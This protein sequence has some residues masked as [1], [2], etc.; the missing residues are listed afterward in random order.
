MLRIQQKVLP[1]PLSFG[2]AAEGFGG[3]AHLEH[4]NNVLDIFGNE[5][6]SLTPVTPLTLQQQRTQK[7]CILFQSV[8]DAHVH[9]N[10]C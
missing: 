5:A 6:S 7:S 1:P 2:G 10:M 9:V 8:P 4:M 3:L